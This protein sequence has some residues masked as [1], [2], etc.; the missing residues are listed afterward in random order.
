MLRLF[1]AIRPPLAIRRRLLAAAG[2]MDGAR[3]QSDDQ[4]HCTLRFF[5]ELG[6]HAADDLLTAL[7][8]L[9]LPAPKMRVEG[10]GSFDRRGRVDTLWARV[11]PRQP[12]AALA[13]RIDRAAEVAGLEPDH[14]AHHPHIT[15]ARGAGMTGAAAW[16]ERT[17][18]LVTDS[19]VPGRWGVYESTLGQGGADYTLVEAFGF[20]E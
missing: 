11:T 5:G 8:S 17:Q 20:S 14:R 4:L 1:A 10:T 13:A 6:G 12:L 19:W 3:W 15:L 16:V 9:S 7:G 18:G 2:G